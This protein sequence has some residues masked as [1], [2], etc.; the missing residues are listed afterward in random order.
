MDNLLLN[1]NLEDVKAN[2]QVG[3]LI[4]GVAGLT[5]DHYL[6]CDGSSIMTAEYSIPLDHSPGSN[7]IIKRQYPNN[8]CSSLLY[9]GGKYLHTT[10]GSMQ[11]FLSYD[12]VTWQ[13]VVGPDVLG[14]GRL[15]AANNM[16]FISTPYNP[17]YYTSI[18][19]I[20]WTKRTMPGIDSNLMTF[21][22]MAYGGQYVWTTYNEQYWLSDNGID[23]EYMSTGL[24]QQPSIAYGNGT[25]ICIT[26][27]PRG[28]YKTSTDGRN[29]TTH[30][31][32]SY[33]WFTGLGI[34]SS[35]FN[36]LRY[37]K[38]AGI[39][40]FNCSKGQTNITLF[41]YNGSVWYYNSELTAPIYCNGNTYGNLESR[42][43]YLGY[44]V[45]SLLD[46][47]ITQDLNI[48]LS[49]S[50]YYRVSNNSFITSLGIF[51]YDLIYANPEMSTLP[52]IPGKYIKVK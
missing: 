26:N 47:H 52:D 29:W 50:K 44:C 30:T 37:D 20:S 42:P 21:M 27:Q 24:L 3:Q 2:R 25:Y 17:T 34:Q 18:D 33:S 39:F 7:I 14:D 12:L 11:C 40:T 32:S 41:T 15:V 10:G 23:W 8:S 6:P 43:G 45:G 31:L 13:E 38:L 49:L 9:H 16:F 36:D 19:A 5:L 22:G 48:Q 51:G 28:T 4:D 1:K 35:W 46:F